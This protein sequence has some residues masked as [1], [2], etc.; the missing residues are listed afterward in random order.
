M[1]HW[2][3]IHCWLCL[4]S[5]SGSFVVAAP[6][7]IP[8]GPSQ[9]KAR[10]QLDDLAFKVFPGCVTSI[11]VSPNHNSNHNSA[12]NVIFYMKFEYLNVFV[13]SIQYMSPF[14]LISQ[15]MGGLKGSYRCILQIS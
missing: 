14:P 7:A 5:G 12:C 2:E 6:L 10:P 1:D 15:E 8:V 11:P 9:W 13:V 4:N 3:F